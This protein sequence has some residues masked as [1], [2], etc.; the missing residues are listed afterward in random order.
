MK[1]YLLYIYLM[2]A[3]ITINNK[4]FYGIKEMYGRDLNEITNDEL[5]ISVISMCHY[6]LT[7]FKIFKQSL[8]YNYKISYSKICE[9][10]DKI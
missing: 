8:I 2:I 3:K 10:L 4:T 5:F 6:N 7:D 9:I 1:E